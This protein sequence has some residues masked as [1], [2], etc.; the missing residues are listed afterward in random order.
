MK[1]EMTSSPFQN[2]TD[3]QAMRELANQFQC[4]AGG[5]NLEESLSIRSVRATT[6]LWRVD[7]KLVAFAFV[8][9]YNNLRFEIDIHS[10][11][12]QLQKEIVDWGAACIRDRNAES[13]QDNTL[14]ASFS[15]RD[16]WQIE[17][18]EK[19]GFKREPIRTLGYSR[20]LNENLPVHALP[21]GFSLRSVKGEQEVEDLV[22]LHRAAFGTDNMTVEERLA[23]MRV[24]GYQQELDLV[25]TASNGELAAFCICGFDEED[26]T[27]G[28]TDPLGAHPRFQRLGLGSAIITAGLLVL[29]NRGARVVELG[30][31]SQN[32]PM[33]KLAESLG[34]ILV[35]EKLWFANKYHNPLKHPTR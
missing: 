22:N 28:Y 1:T 3:I 16:S 15:A 13:G 32:L 11:S 21:A 5:F 27:I 25:V 19:H 34:F 14:D 24:P 4:R 9:D 33:Q 23:I 29:K 31:S 17:M 30:T 35:S 2:E 6:R 18:L 7:G 8:D 10:S 12:E 20:S 26:E